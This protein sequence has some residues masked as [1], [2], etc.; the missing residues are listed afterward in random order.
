MPTSAIAAIVALA[1]VLVLNIV[2]WVKRK[3]WPF[4]TLFV[5]S[6]TSVA[7][8]GFDP[9]IETLVFGTIVL[10]GTAVALAHYA[11]ALLRR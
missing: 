7:A 11:W 9:K 8:A 3:D 6:I 4:I 10:F 5:I 1:L 2:A